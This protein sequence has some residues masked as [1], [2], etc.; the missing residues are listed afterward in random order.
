M[1]FHFVLSDAVP[2]YAAR[3]ALTDLIRFWKRHP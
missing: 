3:G 2:E 1:S